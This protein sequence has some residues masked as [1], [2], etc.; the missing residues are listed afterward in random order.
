MKFKFFELNEKR[1]NGVGSN[2][3]NGVNFKER[4]TKKSFELNKITSLLFFF[5]NFDLFG[6]KSANS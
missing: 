3:E 2:T 6:E 1:G 4:R 5:V